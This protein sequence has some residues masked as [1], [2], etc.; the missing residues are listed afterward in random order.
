MRRG[1]AL[2]LIFALGACVPYPTYRKVRP[3][4]KLMIVDRRQ[5]LIEGARVTLISTTHPEGHVRSR[6]TLETGPDGIVR[7]PGK[8]GLRIEWLFLYRGPIYFWNWCV[9]KP[10]FATYFT[11]G[12]RTKVFADEKL[13]VLRAGPS[14]ACPA[15]FR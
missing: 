11:S 8:R 7:F 12:P 15:D 13:V 10:G 1:L 3:D 6:D 4:V 5:S 14:R 2:L 9:E